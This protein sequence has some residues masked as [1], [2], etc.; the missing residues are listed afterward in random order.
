[1]HDHMRAKAYLA[2]IFDGSNG[3][4]LYQ[5]AGVAIAA[6]WQFVLPVK[7]M[8]FLIGA[9]VIA[10][11]YTGWR[12][13]KH[14]NG[15]KLNS[16]GVGRTLDKS[17]LYLILMLVTRGV[18]SVYELTGALS[19]AWIVGGLIIGRELLSIFENVDAVLGT[20]LAKAFGE[21]WANLTGRKPGGGDNDKTPPAPCAE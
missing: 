9:F 2:H 20:N 10:D 14:L 3:A 12:K 1:M 4:F 18:D 7:G 16:S 19:L 17:L 11:L 21:I 13:S 5:I 15:A 8:L 6:T